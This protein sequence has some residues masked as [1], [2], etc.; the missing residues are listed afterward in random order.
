VG[1]FPDGKPAE[2]FLV[3]GK[4]GGVVRGLLDGFATAVSLALQFGVPLE[5]LVARFTHMSFEPAG[6]TQNP[7]VPHAKSILDY[8]FRWMALK[9][10]PVEALGADVAQAELP[11]GPGAAKAMSA[12]AHVVTRSRGMSLPEG[13]DK[14]RPLM[15]VGG[16]EDAP[17]C[18][19]CGYLTY[20]NGACYRCHNCG[21]S[22]G[23]S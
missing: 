4:E 11:L 9:F 8:V 22:T 12:M 7:D 2:I 18:P 19:D 16:H 1:L 17:P 6:F 5:D 21:Q 3:M 15:S 13:A 14:A 10:I 20:R 23:C